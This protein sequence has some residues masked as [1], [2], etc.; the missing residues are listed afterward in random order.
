MSIFYSSHLTLSLHSS[1]HPKSPAGTWDP[2]AIFARPQYAS[3]MVQSL[4]D[5]SRAGP[6]ESAV[7]GG[8]DVELDLPLPALVA[9]HEH[10]L[11]SGTSVVGTQKSSNNPFQLDPYRNPAQRQA[12]AHAINFEKEKAFAQVTLA[13]PRVPL[14]TLSFNAHARQMRKFRK[15]TEPRGLVP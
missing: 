10:R 6:G 15:A 3:Q 2:R 7:G 1:Y 9:Q 13:Q 12:T 14:S 11:A 4:F 8:D 5:I